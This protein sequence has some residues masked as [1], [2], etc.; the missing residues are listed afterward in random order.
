MAAVR[1]LAALPHLAGQAWVT[2]DFLLKPD[3]LTRIEE[4]RYDRPFRDSA[5]APALVGAHPPAPRR[6]AAA[7][8]E[9]LAPPPPGG[10]VWPRVLEQ[11]RPLVDERDFETWF[12]GTRQVGE[13]NGVLRVSV[14]PLF[15][16]YAAGEYG[17]VVASACRA[18]GV[19]VPIQFVEEAEVTA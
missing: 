17:E 9:A 5:P 3:S 14:A 18:C 15:L 6:K 2:L 16:G 8:T 1:H 4:G 13:V 19:Q 10:G 7:P 11:L 12:R